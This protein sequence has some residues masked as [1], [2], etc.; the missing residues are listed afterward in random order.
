MATILSVDDLQGGENATL[1]E[2]RDHGSSV[3]G[4]LVHASPGGGPGLHHHPYEETF[5]VLEGS[6][7]FTA[8]DETIEAGTGQIVVVPADTAH[9]FVN[10]GDDVLRMVTIHPS[11][12]VIQEF[13]EEE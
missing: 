9:G 8:G 12:H 7:T 11:D 4:F 5:F 10:S 6:V 13:L 1:F 3:S 2:G